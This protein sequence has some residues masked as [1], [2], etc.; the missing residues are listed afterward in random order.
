MVRTELRKEDLG[1]SYRIAT[2]R[3]HQLI[4]DFYEE[5]FDRAGD[6]R[7]DP[8]NIANMVSGMRIAI[9]Q[10]LDLIKEASYEYFEANLDDKSEQ[11]ALF[12]LNRK[13]R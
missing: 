6:P 8:G 12:E 9:N 1:V 11:K 4:T 2:V 10:E 3:L 13:S 7:T 5:L